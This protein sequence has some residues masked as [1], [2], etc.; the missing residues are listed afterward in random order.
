M[1]TGRIGRSFAVLLGAATV[2]CAPVIRQAATE[3]PHKATP[4]VIDEALIAFEKPET[5]K[6]IA[7]ILASPEVRASIEALG[8]DIVSGA[9]GSLGE[10]EAAA[11]LD[12]F[13]TTIVAAFSR[14]FAKGIDRDIVPAI[15]RAVVGSLAEVLA[16]D[17]Q[18]AITAA[19]STT[20]T[21]VTR[22]VAKTFGTEIIPALARS[23]GT[24]LQKPDVRQQVQDATEKATENVVLG[25][26][27]AVTEIQ[28]RSGAPTLREQLSKALYIVVLVSALAGGLIVGLG[29]FVLHLR[30]R[31][32][33]YEE[34]SARQDAVAEKFL[35]ALQSLRGKTYAYDLY[36][37]FD[38]AIESGPGAAELRTV[39]AR[40]GTAPL[41]RPHVRRRV[42]PKR[43]STPRPSEHHEHSEPDRPSH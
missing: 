30:R 3:V 21:A 32:R 6:R 10:K 42:M 36:R 43:R 16:P 12:A 29:G 26:G 4:I 2:G 8:A 15:R 40:A 38:A 13:A 24:E 33:L 5:R 31:M 35:S 28:A 39:L 27:K 25:A 19:L 37:S 9:L 17:R 14:E 20:S 23:L 7:A 18:K 1:V 41:P 34:R 22:D 11:R